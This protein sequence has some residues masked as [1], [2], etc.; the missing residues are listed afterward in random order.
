MLGLQT[1][2]ACWRLYHVSL[3]QDDDATKAR[4]IALVCFQRIW[5]S[6]LEATRNPSI[7]YLLCAG[8]WDHTSGY[9]GRGETPF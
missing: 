9:K 4:A 2:C 3:Q 5:D 7:F 6:G 8:P 1:A